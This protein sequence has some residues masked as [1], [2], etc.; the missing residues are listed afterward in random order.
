MIFR[1]NIC[2]FF[3]LKE[4]SW[5]VQFSF[6]TLYFPILFLLFHY[7]LSKYQYFSPH[8]ILPKKPFSSEAVNLVTHSSLFLLLVRSVGS[9]N[10]IH[11]QQLVMHFHFLFSRGD[12]TVLLLSMLLLF[13]VTEYPKSL[14]FVCGSESSIG[15]LLFYLQITLRI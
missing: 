9:Q 2:L 11:I 10:L 3:F 4:K 1:Y 8:P 6:S 14:L 13:S 5:H 7:L 12:F 15:V